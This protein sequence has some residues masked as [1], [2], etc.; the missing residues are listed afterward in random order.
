M[1]LQAQGEVINNIADTQEK[2]A[3]NIKKANKV[4]DSMNSWTGYFKALVGGSSKSKK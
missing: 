1:Q 4:F 2:T 3:S